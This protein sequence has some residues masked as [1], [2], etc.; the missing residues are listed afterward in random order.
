MR[1]IIMILTLFLIVTLSACSIILDPNAKTNSKDKT[2]TTNDQSESSKN[3]TSYL[4]KNNDVYR[5][6]ITTENNEIPNNKDAYING[7]V[8]ITD[9][10]YTEAILK[11]QP[12]KIRL[13]GNSTSAP[14]KKPF[15]IKFNNKVSIFGLPEA[16]DWVLLANYFDKSNLRNYLA[17]LTANKLENLDF[18]PSSIFVDVYLNNEYFG[19]YLLCEQIEV[20][21][22]RVDIE[23]NY[24][25][26]GIS[27]FLIEADIRAQEEHP[28]MED[29]CYIKT[30]YY[31][32]SFK[33][34][35]N[36][37][38]LEALEQNNQVYINEYLNNISWLKDFL[39]TVEEAI[40]SKEYYEFSE[41]IDVE[42]FVDYYLVQEFFKNV[43][44][45]AL[46]QFYVIDQS[47]DKVRISCGPVWDF[48]IAAGVIDK[49]SEEYTHYANTELF[50]RNFD[51][52]YRQLFE[53]DVFLAQVKYRYKEV[54]KYFEEA[55]EELNT[56]RDAL[57]LAQTRNI[58]RWPLTTER[59]Y[60]IEIYAYSRKY[61]WLKSL[62]EHYNLLFET[63]VEQLKILD[64]YYL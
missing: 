23:N 44:I 38:Y 15:K 59:I 64:K 12:M 52:F 4:D 56:A 55:L 26:T 17:Y 27:S 19:L 48:D 61:L 29:L 18:Q 58:K 13:R 43:D 6:N 45:G 40:T 20:N 11:T 35:D 10:K 63:L 31:T 32:F 46:S 54:R 22:G 30:N 42:S 25:S 16:K 21:E 50:V 39:L 1:K 5:I 8:N 36:D 62:D 41:Y 14:E 47:Q 34:P 24:S 7:W 49:T 60:W 33:Y 57:H 53:N 3:I 51:P 28:G 2:E 9:Q 37:D